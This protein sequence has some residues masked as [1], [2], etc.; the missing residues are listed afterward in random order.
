MPLPQ[1]EGKFSPE[2][3]RA[4]EHAQL[5]EKNFAGDQETAAKALQS[6]SAMVTQWS[7]RVQG[8]QRRWRATWKLLAGNTMDK[9][10]P[11]DVHVPEL[12]KA[13]ETLVPR[14]EEQILEHPVWF[15]VIPSRERD[16]RLADANAAMYEWQFRQAN[17][18]TLVQPAIRDMLVTQNAV[19]YCW[20]DNRK[21]WKN[22]RVI[23]NE[24]NPK[25]GRMERAVKIHRVEAVDYS[26]PRAHLVDPLDFI[27]DTKATDLQE[28]TYVGH[29]FWLTIDEIKRMGEQMG[30]QNLDKLDALSQ[31]GTV[32]TIGPPRA[33]YVYTRDPTARWD[34]QTGTAARRVGHPEPIELV[35]LY[36]KLNIFSESDATRGDYEDVR[37]VIAGGK[38]VLEVRA[39][40]LNDGLRPYAAMRVNRSGHEWYST[41]PFD[42]A[43][44]INQ[45]LDRYH[46]IFLRGAHVAA[47]PMVFAEEDSD[48]PDSLYKVRPFEVFKGVG[49]VRFTTV[50]DGFLRAAP[51]VIGI[52]QRN[53]EETVGSFRIN[54][55][56][57]SD[58][59]ATEATLSLQEGN[60]R[61]RGL[62]RGAGEGMG[63][64]LKVFH[65]LT[66]QF[67]LDDVEFPVLGKRALDLRKATVSLS[68]ADM[69]EGVQFELV[70]LHTM[71]NYGLKATGLQ[72]AINASTPFIVANP[73]SVDQVGIIHTLFRELVGP[74]EADRLVRLQ[75]APEALHSQQEENRGLLAGETM[76]VD[77]SD[78]HFEHLKDLYP[79]YRRAMDLDSDMADNVRGAV[80]DHW[81]KHKTQAVR[82]QAQESVRQQRM[83]QQRQ[84]MAPEAGGTA[85]QDGQS[86]QAGGMSDA[87]S[88]LAFD[89]TAGP[90][91]QTTGENP[92]PATGAGQS[93]YG[94]TGRAGRTTN[95]TE[96]RL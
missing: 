59:T 95:Q 80:L 16:R 29:R 78:P 85:G 47:N 26:G 7:E 36:S 51:L 96:N 10:G 74:E 70:G 93:K 91:G 87:L 66:M 56:Q 8:L 50:P 37:T 4:W 21:R 22:I 54:M 64:M 69:L 27:I 44:R 5:I 13:M 68:P 71:R 75:T 55:G 6:V 28:A 14:I 53:I 43:A 61:T 23:K 83:E 67:S 48:M 84:V 52:L 58:G 42:N 3:A 89:Q 41:G 92:G 2:E 76:E 82:Q 81:L 17:V 73:T 39:N 60:R 24:L 62:V 11:E 25:T 88:Q 20:W 35:V 19:F 45:H 18:R 40:P 86:P 72:A 15:K 34:T 30:W 57:D 77:P 12:F 32:A 46:Q 49:P 79:L 33:Q 9:G 31:Q 38:V 90:G 63:E 94:R 65:K 1:K